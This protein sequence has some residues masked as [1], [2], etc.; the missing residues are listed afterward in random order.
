MNLL[1]TASLSILL[2]R[3]THR[4]GKKVCRDN[5]C[6]LEGLLFVSLP[7]LACWGGTNCRTRL[8]LRGPHKQSRLLLK[9]NSLIRDLGTAGTGEKREHIRQWGWQSG[10]RVQDI[11][12]VL[13]SIFCWMSAVDISQNLSLDL[14]LSCNGDDQVFWDVWKTENAKTFCSISLL[15]IGLDKHLWISLLFR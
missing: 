8:Q 1:L 15:N 10:L 9:L 6:N 12:P 2:L 11:D 13:S 5:D 7:E 3:G 4:V 14:S